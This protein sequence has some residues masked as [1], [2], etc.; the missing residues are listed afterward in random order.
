MNDK[1]N[2]NTYCPKTCPGATLLAIVESVANQENSLACI[3][4]AECGKINKVV[5]AYDDVEVL[6]AIDTSVQETLE[7]I[8]ALEGVLQAKLNA[9]LPLLTEVSQ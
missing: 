2:P 3:L 6:I 8:T 7:R 5:A 1:T 9:V 4:A